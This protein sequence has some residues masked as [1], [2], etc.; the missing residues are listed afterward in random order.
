MGHTASVIASALALSLGAVVLAWLS[1][2]I[3]REFL[4]IDRSSEFSRWNV[5]SARGGAFL[6]GAG[7]LWTAARLVWSLW[8]R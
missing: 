4:D 7:M 5:T 2:R 3:G 8:S 1:V 6:L